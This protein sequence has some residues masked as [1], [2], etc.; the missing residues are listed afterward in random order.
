MEVGFICTEEEKMDDK[1]RV[2]VRFQYYQLCTFDGND[3]TE[4]LYDLTGWL[5]KYLDFP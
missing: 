3:Y 5:K 1:K 4:N 2:T